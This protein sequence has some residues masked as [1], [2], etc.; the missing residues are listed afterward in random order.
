MKDIVNHPQ[1]REVEAKFHEKMNSLLLD[2]DLDKS[3]DEIG[4]EAV[5]NVK[6]Y[7]ILKEFL[8]D[9]NFNKGGGSNVIKRDMR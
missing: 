6:A 5:A 9:M 1:W 3:M 8:D 2:V 4:K 7:R